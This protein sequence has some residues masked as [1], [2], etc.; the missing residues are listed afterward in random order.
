[1]P[2][3]KKNI[4]LGKMGPKQKYD[5]TYNPSWR[6]EVHANPDGIQELYDW[7]TPVPSDNTKVKCSICIKSTPFS[8]ASGGISDCKQ[9]ARGLTHKKLIKA[10]SNSR[11]LGNNSTSNLSLSLGG[12]DG[13]TK[14]ETLQALKVV[15]SNLSFASANGDTERFRAMFPDSEIAKKYSQEETKT[16]YVVQFG[17]APY[18]KSEIVKDF[19]G[20][21]FSFKFDETTTSKVQKQYDGYITYISPL[22]NHRVVTRYVGSLFVGH[23]KAEDLR[24]HFHEFMKELKLD[25]DLL[26]GIGLDGPH[27]NLKFQRQLSEEME[28]EKGNSFL[29]IGTCPLHTVNNAFGEGMKMVKG[30]LDIE[31]FLVDLHSFFKLSAARRE[32]YK[33]LGQVTDVVARFMLRYCSTRWLYIG[34]T[35]LRV[36]EQIDN[37]KLYFLTELPKSAGFK[38]KKGVGASERY[39][40]IKKILD[41]DLLLPCMSFVVYASLIFKPFVLMF[42]KEEPMIHMLYP[43]MQQLVQDLLVKFVNKKVMKNLTDI[44]ELMQYNVNN[45]DDYSVQPDMGTK[46]MSLLTTIVKDKLVQKKFV[47]EVITSFYV[48]S[49]GYLL[50]NLPLGKAVIRDAQYLHP[51]LRR[52]KLEK[53]LLRLV[54]EVATCLGDSFHAYFDVDKSC[55]VDDLKDMIKTEVSFY[56]MET[57]PESFYLIK[58]ATEKEKEAKKTSAGQRAYWKQA[59]EVIV[60]IEEEDIGDQVNIFRR[61]DNYW[62]DIGH[63]T[64]EITGLPKYGK[65]SKLAMCVLVLPHGNAEPERGFSINKFM[66]AIHGTSLDDET[67]IALRLIK[68]H[69]LKCGGMMHVKLTQDLLKSVQQSHHRYT[70]FLKERAEKVKQADKEKERKRLEALEASKVNDERE[71]RRAEIKQH[72][73]DRD[74]LKEGIVVAEEVLN[75]INV[76]LEKLCGGKAIDAKKI[77]RTQIKL[78]MTMDRKRKLEAEVTVVEEKMRKLEKA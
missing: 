27:V 16:K 66:L 71:K 32:D 40:R 15:D 30:Y 21:P 48:A 5:T 8:I 3:E 10:R 39:Q 28:K 41:S 77:K 58:D 9:H 46:T 6:T 70:E 44:N 43:Q 14:A 13:V 78:S 61:I 42:Q 59:Y 49:T 19:A 67:I 52:K 55:T 51:N 62:I 57:I 17:I 64:D 45:T 34:K 1:M 63:I 73:H 69:I 24:D 35:V 23:C 47:E 26:L 65:L 33:A 56:R 31:Q 50:A 68:D 7:V 76:E 18:V 38:G 60:G 20:S 53:P 22:A 29:P 54:G 74:V 25:T 75:E 4:I 12:K 11:T 37:I 2:V 72:E 36:M